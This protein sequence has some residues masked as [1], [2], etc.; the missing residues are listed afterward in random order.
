MKDIPKDI[1]RLYL[2]NFTINK[3]PNSLINQYTKCLRFYL[4]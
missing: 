1:I 4:D 3:T 2:K